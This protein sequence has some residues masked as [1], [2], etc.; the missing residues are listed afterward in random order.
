MERKKKPI[1]EDRGIQWRK[2]GGGF[3][4]LSNRIIPPGTLFWAKPEDIPKGFKDQVVPV[5]PSEFKRYQ[6]PTAEE[7][8]PEK[9]FEYTKKLREGSSTWWDIFD[10]NGKRVNEKALREEAANEYLESLQ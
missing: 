3:L 2:I 9:T 8:K 5:D 10:S 6:G 4:R 1:P 7:M